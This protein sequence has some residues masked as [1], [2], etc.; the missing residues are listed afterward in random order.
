MPSEAACGER[1]ALGLGA[2]LRGDGAERGGAYGVVGVAGQRA[3]L[4]T[5]RGP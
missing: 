4:R 3:V 2:L 1:G 5:R